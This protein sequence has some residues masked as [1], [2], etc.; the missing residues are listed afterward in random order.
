MKLRKGLLSLFE[1]MIINIHRLYQLLKLF[2]YLVIK[3]PKDTLFYF[4]WISSLKNRKGTLTDDRPWF[5]F[6]AIKW[7]NS[8]L[9]PEMKIFEYGSGGSTIFFT[10]RVKS[11]VS[12]EHDEN[13]YRFVSNLLERMQ[14]SNVTYILSKP[15]K[16]A[17]SKKDVA[18]PDDYSSG[19]KEYHGLDFSGYVKEIDK[20]LDASFDLIIIDGRARPACIKHAIRKLKHGGV[21]ILDNVDRKRYNLAETQYLSNFKS[22]HFFGIGPYNTIP[23]ETAIY[24]KPSNF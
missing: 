23:W 9:K 4:D 1:I 17:K 13:W 8:Y 20:Y 24:F 16:V 22:K 6:K 11:L 10:K 21:I 12:V 15:I 3:Y 7:L 19:F 14:L 18:N 5:T 2:L